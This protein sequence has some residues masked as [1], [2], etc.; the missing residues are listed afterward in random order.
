MSLNMFCNQCEQTAKGTGCDL[1][2]VCGK[3]AQTSALQDLLVYA[4]TGIALY[5]DRARPLG[6]VDEETDRFVIEGLFTTVTNVNFDPASIQEL[7]VESASILE[8]VRRLFTE[9]YE[10]QSGKRFD[11][12]LPEQAHF[13]PA[14]SLAALIEQGIK[15]GPPMAGPNLHPDIRSLKLLL[16]YG[17]KGMA[18][19]ADHARI[20]GR[21]DEEVT[22]YFHHGLSVL[23]DPRMTAEGLLAELMKFGNINFKC[24]QILDEA[25]NAHF[26]YPVPTK[27]SLGARKGYAILVSGHDLADLAELLKQTDGK[28]IFVYTHGEMLPAHGYPALKKYAHLAGNYGGAWQDQAKEFDQFPGPILM[29]T[30]CIQEPRASYRNRIFTTGLVAWPA[31]KK[32]ASENGKKD[33]TPVIETSIKAGGFNQDIPGREIAVGF[34]HKTVLGLAGQI[35][36]AVKSGKIR[37]FFLVGGC[38]G[39]KPGRNYYT[40][41]AAQVPKDCVILTLA[42]GKYRFNK[43]EFGSIGPIPRLLDIGQCNDAYSAIEIAVALSKALN[44]GV[45][46][47]PLSLVLSWYEQKAVCILITLLALGIKNIRIG[48]SLPA[49]V[50]PNVLKILV[51]QFGLMPIKNAQDDLTAAL[52]G[53]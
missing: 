1:K 2:G 53:R 37:R 6:I 24:M 46:D 5:A 12:P 25:H 39:A 23:A 33:F 51:E 41:F 17:L 32:I 52:A 11:G 43:T 35:L 48:P 7:I 18:A 4:L 29:T 38:D 45:N 49:F 14:G 50:S 27:V 31:V 15:I 13:K 10:K 8:R 20:L 19:Y 47:L 16:L 22:S 3:D 26:G 28:G 44:C 30:N 34:G 9:G 42:C 36:E 21:T 40:D